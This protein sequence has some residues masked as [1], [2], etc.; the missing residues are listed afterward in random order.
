MSQLFASGG[1]VL[2]IQSLWSSF[3]SEDYLPIVLQ[4]LPGITSQT[5]PFSVIFGN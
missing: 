2:R 4:L 5:T 3:P 1:P